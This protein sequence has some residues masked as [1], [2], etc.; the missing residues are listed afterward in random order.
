MGHHDFRLDP[1]Q[2]EP[3][4]ARQDGDGNLADF[5]GG[6]DEFDVGRRFFQRL[7]KRVEGG[8]RQHVHFV[9]D[10]DLEARRS[11][12][13]VHAVNDLTDVADPGARGCVH[14]HHVDVA[15][16]GD[17][18][19]GFALAAGFGGGAA[20]AVRADAVQAF[21]DDAG[22][23]GLADPA[24]AGHHESMGDPVRREGVLQGADHRLLPDE[25]GKGGGAVLAGKDLIG[26]LVGHGTLVS[27]RQIRAR[28]AEGP[29]GRR[30]D[31][32]VKSGGQVAQHV[33]F[34]A[35]AGE[36]PAALEADDEGFGGVEGGVRA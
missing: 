18:D 22:G 35:G 9:N 1:F 12:P 27:Q 25:V 16:F 11:R 24:N 31:R 15:A 23:G 20:S 17:G 10:V 28:W 7:Q 30:S 14:F 36:G 32:P 6:E 29:P 2:V 5:G 13:V 21:G 8:G 3:L 34:A 33:G 19:A 26:G 4:A